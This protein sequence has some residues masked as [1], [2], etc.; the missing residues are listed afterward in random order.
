MVRQRASGAHRE[1]KVAEV[2]SDTRQTVTRTVV[3]TEQ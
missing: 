2:V 3:S 1:S